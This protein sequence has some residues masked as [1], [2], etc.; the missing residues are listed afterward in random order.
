MLKKLETLLNDVSKSPLIDQGDLRAASDLIL[1]AIVTGLNVNRSGIWLYDQELSGIRCFLLKDLS[2]EVPSE[3][4]VLQRKDFPKYF[5]ALDE[6]RVIAANDAITATETSEFAVGYLDVLG[7]SSMLDTPI[8]H[9]GSTVGI[10]CSEHRGSPRIWTDDEIVFAG[11]LSDL[12]GRA[13]SAREKL[14]YELKL[15]EVNQNLELLV[16][17]RTEHLNKTINELTLLQD[18]LVE[19]E[20][21]AALGNMVAGIAH[22][23]NTPLGIALTATSHIQEGIKDISKGLTDQT[24]TKDGLKQSLAVISQAADL[25]AGNLDRAAVLIANFKRTS[26]DQN[27]FDEHSIKLK[28]Y[29]KQVLTTL[30][31]ITKKMN[32]Q[33]KVSGDD[34]ELKTF[35]GAIAQVLTNFVTNSCIHGFNQDHHRDPLID[36]KIQTENGK[37]SVI[38]ADNGMGMD[39]QTCK[40]MF[41]P[42]FTTNRN[43]GGT[44]LGLSIVHAILIK[45]LQAEI[46]VKSVLDKGTE[47]YITF[48]KLKIK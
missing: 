14:D 25:S 20:K 36:I 23:V 47:F 39:E 26:A 42:F 8:R 21:M 37:L 34:I 46:E 15:I 10:I 4:I 19:S 32:V 24:L 33:V 13:I 35:P 22:E 16:E 11:V 38:Y 31:P 7:I 3:E 27:H 41:D 18:K 17:S 2:L 5:S 12:F 1:T 30:T 29:I 43:D 9:S 6:D 40:K 44:G 28:S 45:K 48:P